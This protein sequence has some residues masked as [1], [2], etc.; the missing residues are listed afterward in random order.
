MTETQSA[1]AG[2]TVAR[3]VFT[4]IGFTLVIT[5][6]IGAV[7]LFAFTQSTVLVINGLGFAVVGV[8]LV[9]VSRAIRPR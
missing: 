6:A 4:V 8:T 2:I 9:V 3:Y 5:G 1:S 7:A